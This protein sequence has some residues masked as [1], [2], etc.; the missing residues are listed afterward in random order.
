MRNRLVQIFIIALMFLSHQPPASAEVGVDEHLGETL[1]LDLTFTDEDGK[2]VR[3]GDAIDRPTLLLLVYFRCP[4]LCGTLMGGVADMVEVMDIEPGESYQVI[5][6]SFDPT[7]GPD[8]AK[9]KKANYYKRINRELDP[10]DWRFFTG[11]QE[12]IDAIVQ[13]VGF[14]Y[15]PQGKDFNH[16]AV[17][18]VVSAKGKISR[19]LYGVEFLAFDTKMAIMEAEEGRTGPSISPARRLLLYCFSYDPEGRTYVFN[20]LKVIATV[21]LLVLVLFGLFLGL[22]TRRYRRDRAERLALEQSRE[23]SPQTSQEANQEGANDA[24]SEPPSKEG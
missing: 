18:T 16:P 3:L 24:D 8:L 17:L 5:A 21:S 12:N 15:E 6:I 22:T 20:I 19:Y 23:K 1:P 14:Q 9:R 2:E 4:G 7:E 11:D 10:G 13:A